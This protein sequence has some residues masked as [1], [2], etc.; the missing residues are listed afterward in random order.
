[1]EIEEVFGKVLREIRLEK[2]NS[3]EELAH[4]CGL[5]SGKTAYN[6]PWAFIASWILI[7][8]IIITVIVTNGINM[9]SETRIDGTEAQDVL[10]DLSEEFPVASGG[11]GISLIGC[12]R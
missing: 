4:I 9:S 8:G 2:K 6:K 1:M 7:L 10:D 5:I 11:Q 3:Q 12:E